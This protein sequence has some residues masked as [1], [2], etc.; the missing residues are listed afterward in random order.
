MT[1]GHLIGSQNIDRGNLCENSVMVEHKIDDIDHKVA[2]M[3][4]VVINVFDSLMLRCEE[5]M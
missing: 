5:N 2:C 3:Y 4:D 1:I